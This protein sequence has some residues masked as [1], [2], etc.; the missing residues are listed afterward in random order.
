MYPLKFFEV[1]IN[2]TETIFRKKVQERNL[3]RPNLNNYLL[4]KA[5]MPH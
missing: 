2:C 4:W 1:I 3:L 5:S